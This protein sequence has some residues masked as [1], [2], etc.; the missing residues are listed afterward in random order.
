VTTPPRN[1]RQRNAI[2]QAFDESTRP[3]SPQ[4]V[5]DWGRRRVANMSLATVYRTLAVLL[6]EKQITRVELPGQPPLYELAGLKH[7]HHFHCDV[8]GRTFDIEGC[9]G[10]LS[11]MVPP[12]FELKRHD[13][14]LFGRCAACVAEDR[15]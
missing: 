7:H 12:G 15:R 4:E 10:D 14:T 3:L 5:L 13:L 8:C 6:E 9:P 11:R 1:T 2:R